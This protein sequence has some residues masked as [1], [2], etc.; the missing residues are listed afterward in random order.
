[1]LTMPKVL[2]SLLTRWWWWRRQSRAK[3]G[4]LVEQYANVDCSEPAHVSLS[5]SLQA[6][7]LGLALCVA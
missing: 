5:R 7:L 2:V 4:N 3:E 6:V 1:M